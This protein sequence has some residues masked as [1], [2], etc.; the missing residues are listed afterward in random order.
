MGRD[1]KGMLVPLLS[2]FVAKVIK[3]MGRERGGGVTGE[4]A[5][6]GR[7]VRMSVFEEG[8]SHV[9][10]TWVA[11]TQGPICLQLPG[12]EAGGDGGCW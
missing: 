8:G 9:T 1:L 3:V 11:T 7:A 2:V 6:S 10:P 4:Q 12:A 5:P